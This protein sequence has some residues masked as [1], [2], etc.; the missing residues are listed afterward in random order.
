MEPTPTII[1]GYPEHWPKHYNGSGQPCDMISGPC[2][3]KSWHKLEEEWVTA[4]IEQYGL[5]PTDL[6]KAKGSAN[7]GNRFTGFLDE[8]F[9]I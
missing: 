6:P 9:E 4:Y 2:C 8:E 3:C 5:V 7:D 1:A